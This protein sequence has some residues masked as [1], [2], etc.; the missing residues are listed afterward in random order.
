MAC[1]RTH[2]I[3]ARTTQSSIRLQQWSALVPNH[4]GRPH[5]SHGLRWLAY[6]SG[7]NLMNTSKLVDLVGEY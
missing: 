1:A 3:G 4:Y 5:T 6:D 7:V 2:L